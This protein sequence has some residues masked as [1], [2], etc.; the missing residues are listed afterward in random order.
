MKKVENECVGCMD[1]GL[2]CLGDSCP[3]KNIVHYYCDFCKEEDVR[4]Y[5]YDGYEICEDCLLKEFD[6]VEG[7]EYL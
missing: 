7:S 2:Y 6:V 5:E 3:N 1:L 4:L